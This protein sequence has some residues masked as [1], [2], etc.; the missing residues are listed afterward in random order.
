MGGN[1]LTKGKRIPR[2]KYLIIEN[3]IKEYLNKTIGTDMYKIPRYYDTKLD[4]GD[5]D[6]LIDNELFSLNKLNEISFKDRIK[7]D[8]DLSICEFNSGILTTL[9]K[10]FQVDYFPTYKNKLPMLKDFMDYNIGNFI[11]KI[12]RRFN[13]KYGMDGLSYV[14]RGDDNH[15]KKTFHISNDMK[16]IFELFDLDYNQWRNGFY[17]NIDSYKWVINSKFF[18]TK[19]YYN[20]RGG[21]KKRIKDR[22][23]FENFTKWLKDNNIERSFEFTSEDAK[24]DLINYHF[25]NINLKEFIENSE[26][27][28]NTIKRLRNKFN[29]NIIMNIYPNLKGKKLGNF[30]FKFKQYIETDY[31]DFMNY[32]VNLDSVEIELLIRKFYENYYATSKK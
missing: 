25:P 19:T 15:Y 30:I 2:D 21:T 5:L 14:Y 26:K 10:G 1:L 12:A 23:E 29:G 11:G 28:Y 18:S 32:M 7:N 17:S 24:F 20:P 8:L 13:L 4:F 6:I 22:P 9:Y 31:G 16:K 27:E 3:E